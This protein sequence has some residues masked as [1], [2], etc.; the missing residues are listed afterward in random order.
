MFVVGADQDRDDL[1]SQA[2]KI[3]YEK[4]AGELT[5]GMAAWRAAGNRLRGDG[6]GVFPGDELRS[7]RCALPLADG[8]PDRGG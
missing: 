1:V 7:T 4:L 8:P 3:G 6:Q 2:L 5:G